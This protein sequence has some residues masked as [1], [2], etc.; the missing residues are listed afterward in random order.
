MLVL[1]GPG[2]NGG[3]G[4]AAGRLALAAGERVGVMSFA[5]PDS[6]PEPARSAA[7]AAIAAGVPWERSS[8]LF[9]LERALSATGLVVDALF[10]VGTRGMLREPY[11][12]V[13]AAVNDAGVPVLA[14]DLPTGAD[15]DSGALMPVGIR[16]DVTVTFGAVKRGLLQFPAAEA[17]GLVVVDEIGLPALPEAS[18]AV[19]VWD[20][21][22]LRELIPVPAPD[23]HKSTRG[24][25]LVVAGSAGM[26]GAAIL[27]ASAAQRAGAGYVTLAV[28]ASL[29]DVADAGVTSAV[30]VGLPETHRRALSEESVHMVLALAARCDAVVVGPGLGREDATV[31]AIRD[32]VAACERPM[33]VDADALNA[34]AGALELLEARE[35]PTVL[36]PHPGEAARLLGADTAEVNVD[37]YRS[38]ERLQGTHRAVV[39]KGARS[40]IACDGRLAVN[41]TGNPGMA[42]TGTG[43]VLAGVVGTLLAQG[44]GPYEAAVLGAYLHGRAGDLAALR[45]GPIGLIAE[46]LTPEL[47]AAVRELIEA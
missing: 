35:A 39:V 9:S 14:V 25:V 20:A 26:S 36:T 24:R 41:M 21:E 11:P 46:D 34:V 12:A 22:D 37:R 38:A 16:A 31:C 44:L 47:P 3:D 33:V 4:W 8:D 43:D 6:L 7:A 32:I 1:A 5:D 45:I 19:E 40:V 15:A 27:A 42:T 29:L 30:T 10:G 23:A 28:P 17:A 2:N 18:G 13:V